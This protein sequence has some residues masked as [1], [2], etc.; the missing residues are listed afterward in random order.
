MLA[1]N[2]VVFC[3][4]QNW[5]QYRKNRTFLPEQIGLGYCT[6]LIFSFAKL[7][8]NRMTTLEWNEILDNG[9]G[10]YV[11]TSLID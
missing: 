5:S 3:Y 1:Q 4:Y 11:H 8:Q 7:D 6:H 10:L 9:K 2:K